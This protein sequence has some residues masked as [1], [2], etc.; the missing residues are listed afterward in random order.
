MTWIFAI[1]AVVGSAAAPAVPPK[2]VEVMVVGTYHFDNPG[3]DLHNPKVDDVLKPSRQHELKALSAALA[4]FRPTKIMVERVAKTPDL[5]DPRYA[6]FRPSDLGRNR[7]ERVQIAYRLAQ[8]LDHK[9]VYAVDEQP[10]GAEP[11]YFPFGRVADWAKANGA[12]PQLNAIMVSGAAMAARIEKLQAGNSIG[13]ALA[14]LNARDSIGL[15]HGLY[16]GMLEIGDTVQQPGAELN[17]MWYMRNAKI[18]AK[19]MRVDKPGDRVLLVYGSGHNYW[20]RHFAS[21][22]PGYREVDPVP[23]LKEARAGR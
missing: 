12:E 15:D 7:D 6:E 23:Y 13:G 1:T 8:R 9:T 21:T 17:A 3:R 5:V 2:P 19:L 10:E 18:F 16:Y 14:L 11:D 20:L 22:T 4:S